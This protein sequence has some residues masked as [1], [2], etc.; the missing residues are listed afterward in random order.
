MVPILIMEVYYTISDPLSTT[1]LYLF[2]FRVAEGPGA[3]GVVGV[4][5][6]VRRAGDDVIRAVQEP[7]TPGPRVAEVEAGALDPPVAL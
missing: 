7:P 1:N 5:L 2:P 3:H 4:V 6:G